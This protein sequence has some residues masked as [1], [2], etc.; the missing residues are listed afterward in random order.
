MIA[1]D[2]HMHTNYSSDSQEPMEEQIKGSIDAGLKGICITDHMDLYYPDIEDMNMTFMYDIDSNY[3]DIDLFR[4]RYSGKLEIL[5]G[6]E[7]GLRNEP[8]LAEKTAKE[9]NSLIDRSDIDFIIG[10]THCLEYCD[11]YLPKYWEHHTPVD[12]LRKYFLAVLDNIRNNTC[13]DSLGHL[14][15]LVRYVPVCESGEKAWAGPADYHVGDYGDII[16]EILRSIIDRGIA[17]EV[18]SAGLK[19]GIGFAHPKTEILRRYRELKGELIT[20]GSDSHRQCHVAYDFPVV[21]EMLKSLGFDYYAV[22]RKRKP[23]M[24]KFEG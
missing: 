20:I 5:K 23:N 7:L 14:D 21:E 3:K 19:Y 11:P 4:D 9:Y 15:Y 16:D 10:S 12:G 1:F 2:C 22:Y 17:L 6:I 18:N 24:F 13:F 8:D